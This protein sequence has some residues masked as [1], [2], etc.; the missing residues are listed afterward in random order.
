MGRKLRPRYVRRAARENAGIII[1]RFVLHTALSGLTRTLERGE[2]LADEQE[3]RFIASMTDEAVNSCFH[4]LQRRPPAVSLAFPKSAKQLPMITIMRETQNTEAPI[5]GDDAGVVDDDLSVVEDETVLT[6]DGGAVGGEDTFVLP[7]SGEL[8]AHSVDVVVRRSGVGDEPLYQNMDEYTVVSTTKTITLATPLLAGEELVVTRY[9]S[10]GMQG[11][12]LEAATYRFNGVIFIE[13]ENPAITD[14][15]EAIVWRELFLRKNAL[16]TSGLVDL[17]FGFRAISLWEQFVPAIGF[18]SEMTV[19]CLLDWVAYVGNEA[20]DD[21]SAT[22]TEEA[23][24]TTFLQMTH[25]LIV[26][27]QTVDSGDPVED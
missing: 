25:D 17:D 20:P 14:F 12:D 9:A 5:I 13:T 8:Y 3:E 18:R 26:W 19:S 10:K 15:L 16:I 22:M 7:C 23:G 6:P 2:Y 21:A 11:G 24:G 27:E 1:P 4:Y